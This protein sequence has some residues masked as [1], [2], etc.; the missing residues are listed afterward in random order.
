MT[1]MR[2]SVFVYYFHLTIQRNELLIK[3][4]GIKQNMVGFIK[5]MRSTRRR[6]GK[7]KKN[8]V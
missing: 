6:I 8:K 2:L 7:T 3:I 4:R 5:E 1:S